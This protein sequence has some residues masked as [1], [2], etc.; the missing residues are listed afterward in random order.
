MQTHPIQLADVIYNAA[1]QSY[2]ALVTVHDGAQTRKYACSI[3]APLTTS[4]KDA[5][6]GLSK[7]ALRRH[8]SRGGIFSEIRAANVAPRAG[9]QKF[10]PMQWLEQLISLPGR[11]AA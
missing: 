4:F 6:S 8:A 2:E 7:Q 10:D 1:N 9:R 11:R 3:N 5:A